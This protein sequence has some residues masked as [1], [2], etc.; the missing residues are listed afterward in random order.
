M[1]ITQ[2]P[3]TPAV[4]RAVDVLDAVAHNVA[5]TPPP[6]RRNGVSVEF[7]DLAKNPKGLFH[8]GRVFWCASGQGG[9][10]HADA[11][12]AVG[13]AA[14]QE[15][16]HCVWT[17]G[18]ASIHSRSHHIPGRPD[19]SPTT[20]APSPSCVPSPSTPPATYRDS[21]GP[22]AQSRRHRPPAGPTGRVGDAAVRCHRSSFQLGFRT[23]EFAAA[24]F[25][26]SGSPTAN[27]WAT[28][29]TGRRDC[30][31]S[32]SAAAW[33]GPAR[34]ASDEQ[35]RAPRTGAPGPRS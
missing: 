3:R 11:Q 26:R 31:S 22:G 28:G 23:A 30:V 24:M 35:R 33:A 14:Q 12:F 29:F 19:R 2:N 32:A 18:W 7:R 20:P 17:F 13:V 16:K 4:N 5:T 1:R 15:P 34:V 9:E 10:A 6:G 27:R 25:A 21:R 8:L